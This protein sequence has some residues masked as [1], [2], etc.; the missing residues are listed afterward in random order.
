MFWFGLGLGVVV[1]ALASG[2]VAIYAAR[3][4]ARAVE[5]LR[6]EIED[7]RQRLRDR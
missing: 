3:L 5:E 6:E 4:W 2:V 1:G 7:L